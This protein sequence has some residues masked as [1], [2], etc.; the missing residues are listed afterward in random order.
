MNKVLTN[1]Q[2]RHK[3]LF[4]KFLDTISD[5][6]ELPQLVKLVKKNTIPSLFFQQLDLDRENAYYLCNKAFR[7]DL[8]NKH[9]KKYRPN[10]NF[11]DFYTDLFLKATNMS[12]FD[13][14]KHAEQKL[15]I[16]ERK[17]FLEV[18]EKNVSAF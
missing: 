2:L 16:R 15:E 7:P 17:N 12:K 3:I 18:W 5:Q 4:E 10:E 8:I 1:Q 11:E 6:V 13:R 14:G 9:A